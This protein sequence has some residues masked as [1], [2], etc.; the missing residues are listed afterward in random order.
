MS[1]D[2]KIK[3]KEARIGYV[4]PNKSFH[5]I[6]ISFDND[7]NFSICFCD[8]DTPKV[9]ADKLYAAAHHIGKDKLINGGL[10]LD[11]QIKEGCIM[12][13]QLIDISKL[14]KAKV[15]AALYNNSKPLGMGMLHYT[16]KD[17]MTSEAQEILNTGQTYFDYLIGRVMKSE[18]GGDNFDPCLYDRDNG[19]G[20]ALKAIE[21]IGNG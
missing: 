17:M 3:F 10:N 21:S 1:D 18:I 14:D 2:Q 5:E 8:K 9:I 16:P 6:I 4:P 20:A 19:D 7:T 12:S 15:L 11:L 13:E